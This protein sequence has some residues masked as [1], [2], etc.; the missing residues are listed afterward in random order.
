LNEAPAIPSLR[1]ARTTEFN[2]NEP[3]RNLPDLTRLTGTHTPRAMGQTRGL[4]QRSHRDS[5]SCAG[6]GRMVL[7]FTGT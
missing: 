1:V 5:Y 2:R 3:D 4:P 6:S 7:G